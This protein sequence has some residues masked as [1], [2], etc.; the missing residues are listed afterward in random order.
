MATI[1]RLVAE[2]GLDDS[3]FQKG[4]KRSSSSLAEWGKRVE[5]AGRQLSLKLTAP[6]TGLGFAAMRTFGGFNEQMTNIAALVGVPAAELEK[7]RQ[8]VLDLAPAVGIGPAQLAEALYFITSAGIPA[9]QAMDVLEASAKA[10]AA[11]L[12]DTVTVADL[13]TSAMNAYAASGLTAEEA[14]SVLV[15]TVRE[16]KAEPAELAASL[17]QVI[18]TAAQLNVSFNDVGAAVAV[19]TQAGLDA[20]EATT[21]LNQVLLTLLSPSAEAKKTLAEFGLTAEELRNQLGS[22]GLLPVLR[23]LSATF[24][25]NEEAIAN[26]FGNVRALRGFLNITGQDAEKVDQI[27]KELANST[28]DL[29]K[30]F[31][32]AA[33]DPMFKLRQAMARIKVALVQIGA[34]MVPVVVPAIELL[35]KVVATL[36]GWFDKLPKPVKIVI[37]VFAGLLAALGPV[38]VALGI[39]AQAIAALIP[40][41]PALGAAISVALGPVGLVIMAIVAALALLAV[42]YKKNWLGFGDAVRFVARAVAGWIRDII[43]WFEHLWSR[44]RAFFKAVDLISRRKPLQGM[45]AL[46]PA[47][48]TVMRLALLFGKAYRPIRLFTEGLRKIG[49][50]DTER[51]HKILNQL[52]APLAKILIA[53]ARV[54]RIV[55]RFRAAWEKGGPVLA[56]RV[57]SYELEKLGRTIGNFFKSIGFERFGSLIAEIAGKAGRI[58]RDVVKLVDDLVH[59][60]WR[61]AWR[62]YVRLVEDSI[63]LFALLFKGVP[64]AVADAFD[65]I[66]SAIRAVDWGAVA[67]FLLTKGGELISGLYNGAIGFATGTLFPWLGGLLSQVPG[68]VGDALG[69]LKDKGSDLIKGLKDGIDEKWKDI[70]DFAKNIWTKITELVPDALKILKTDGWNLVYGMYIG[71]TEF[72]NQWIVP[73]FAAVWDKIKEIVPDALK[74]LLQ[75]GKD[76]I[77]GLKDGIDEKWADI[78]DFAKN[79]WNKIT[80]LVPDALTI[81]KTDGWNLIYGIYIGITEFWNQWI[82][83]FVSGLWNKIIELVPDALKTLYQKGIDLIQGLKDGIDE[84]WS[85]IE[86]FAKNIWNNITELVPDALTILKT[87]GWNLI[88]GVYIGMTEFWNQWVVPFVSAI[89]NKVTELV[90]DA[91]KVLLQ[92]GKDLIQG[93]K[94]GIDEKWTDIEN[95]A[96]EI[97]NKIGELIPDALTILKTDGW[98]LVYG[99]YIGATEFWNQ[100]I[101]PFFS[102]IWNKVTELVP[103]A[104]KVLLQKGKDLI[105]GIVDGITEKW[106][107]VENWAKDVWTTIDNLV[108]NPIRTLWQ[109]GWNLV[110][111]IYIGATEFWNKWIVPFV[112]GVWNKVTALVPDALKVLYQKGVD[113]IQGLKD[114]IDA[115]WEEIKNFFSGI[116]QAIVDALPDSWDDVQNAFQ[117][118]ADAITEVLGPVQGIIDSIK[119][120]FNWAFGGG[121]G[122]GKEETAPTM[123]VGDPATQDV[124]T[125]LQNSGGAMGAALRNGFI[126]EFDS[127]DGLTFVN[128]VVGKFSTLITVLGQYPEQ[129][130]TKGTDMG[131]GLVGSFMEQMTVDGQTIAQAVADDFSALLLV[132]DGYPDQFK[133]KGATMGVSLSGGFLDALAQLITAV[134]TETE[135]LET[136]VNTTLE[137][138]YTI[139]TGWAKNTKTNVAKSFVEMTTSVITT[140]FALKTGV[141]TQFIA[142]TTA[143]TNQ[144]NSLKTNVS[145]AFSDMYV[146][147]KGW[148]KNAHDAVVNALTFPSFYNEGYD[149]GYSLG[150]GINNGIAAWTSAI[151]WTAWNAVNQAVQAAK[152]AAGI[153]SPSKVMEQMGR[154]LMAGLE[155]GIR[156]NAES[157]AEAMAA[158]LQPVLAAPARVAPGG[159]ATYT[160]TI[161]V[162]GAGDPEAVARATFA[163]FS[164]QLR[165]R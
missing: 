83:P 28:G 121:G 1:A 140:S 156:L 35:S 101:V 154:Y 42:A 65:Q 60:N 117:G 129:F 77:Q 50:R 51:V 74:A 59:G 72:W 90:P 128:A 3:N 139:A 95:F 17:G 120:A 46:G 141:A 16:G 25:D 122:G 56:F 163:E 5:H 162:S 92:K 153:A 7:L 15:A 144:A 37:V 49:G 29:N 91:L 10:A 127:V 82:V 53:F 4:L 57:L 164:R 109:K 69:W 23:R 62:D 86:D 78:E 102:A 44:I 147:V 118:L 107:D 19:M 6:I 146:A 142:M 152:Q 137:D 134:T 21:S 45:L 32:I 2:L 100:W 20:A 143:A 106:A 103:D 64:S 76:L 130:K 75:K 133:S 136:T 165:K 27:F 24:G 18:P 11:G 125:Q 85:D 155:R 115:K 30:A 145:T 159:N 63:D 84:K 151:A 124:L 108:P 33:S 68:A 43:G 126:N 67:S 54:I 58:I 61:A 88:Y 98:N 123:N 96:K 114:G 47:G 116:A 9:S 41:L 161:N 158:A 81:L 39:A 38:L 111:G 36:A 131:S 26:V 66:L 148:A 132:L 99:I 48:T 22:E 34:A 79:I 94:D 112:S 110:Y 71:A 119:G 73:F 105:Q 150:Q 138:M 135:L 55:K 8:Q 70:E 40:L 93:L 113:L 87:D 13:A 160:V 14:V 104:L 12:G 52:P 97:W 89:W 157:P 80:E 149:V 31:E